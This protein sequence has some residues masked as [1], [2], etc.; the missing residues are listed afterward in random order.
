MD[1]NYCVRIRMHRMGERG[2]NL[3]LPDPCAKVVD[4]LL[5][6]HGTLDPLAVVVGDAGPLKLF[7]QKKV[8]SQG[9]LET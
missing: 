6:H 4:P 1:T 2:S 8:K 3:I 5:V 9:Q 7:E